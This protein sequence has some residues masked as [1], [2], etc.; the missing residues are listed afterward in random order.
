[1]Q[2]FKK[3]IFASGLV[4][5]SLMAHLVLNPILKYSLI[6]VSL[7]DEDEEDDE[8]NDGESSSKVEYKTVYTKLPDTVVYA[9]KQIPRY[10]SDSDG[11]YDD[12][13]PH[14]AINEFFIVKDDNLNGI[15]DQYEQ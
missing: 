1:M 14:P 5:L 6:P 9:K 3:I 10:D 2:I 12:E 15:D 7:A 8:E 4:A 11:L 13:D